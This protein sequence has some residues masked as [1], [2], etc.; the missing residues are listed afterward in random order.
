MSAAA[1]AQVVAELMESN[2]QFRKLKRKHA[3]YERRLSELGARRFP[4]Y[5]EQLEEARLKKLKL[6]L[7]DRMA[8]IVHR[9]VGRTG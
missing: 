1:S 2:P 7:K 4:T 8:S 6:N 5:E 9:H 3:D